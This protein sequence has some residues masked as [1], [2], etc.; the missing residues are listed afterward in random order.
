MATKITVRETITKVTQM[1]MQMM[2]QDVNIVIKLSSAS[3]TQDITIT[4]TI[5]MVT[6]SAGIDRTKKEWLIPLFF[7]VFYS[8]EIT[9]ISS[10][11]VFFCPLINGIYKT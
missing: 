8:I 9:L 10:V 2:L 4:T 11:K 6:V 7:Y 3:M 1:A 5:V